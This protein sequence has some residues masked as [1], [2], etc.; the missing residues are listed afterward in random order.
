VT[1]VIPPARFGAK[2][3]G[4]S[5][6][7]SVRALAGDGGFPSGVAFGPGDSGDLAARWA[8]ECDRGSGWHH[9]Y[10]PGVGDR[11]RFGTVPFVAETRMFTV[12]DPP[13]TLS[14]TRIADLVM[15]NGLAEAYADKDWP[16]RSITVMGGSVGNVFVDAIRA[17]LGD[18]GIVVYI[19]SRS[20]VVRPGQEPEYQQGGFVVRDGGHFEI[21]GPLTRMQSDLITRELTHALVEGW[22]YAP[23][24][25]GADQLND[26]AAT[27][28][29]AADLLT[30]SVAQLAETPDRLDLARLT[31][32]AA[33]HTHAGVVIDSVV[34]ALRARSLLDPVRKVADLYE[35][36]NGDWHAAAVPIKTRRL[37][38]ATGPHTGAE[39][40]VLVGGG[41]TLQSGDATAL[42]A[43]PVSAQERAA[44]TLWLAERAFDAVRA[45]EHLPQVRLDSTNDGT[46]MRIRMI[47]D[48]KQSLTRWGRSRRRSTTS[49]RS[50]PPPRGTTSVPASSRCGR[51]LSTGSVTRKSPSRCGPAPTSTGPRWRCSAAPSEMS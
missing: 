20:D 31:R 29:L 9:Q 18:P 15:E 44:T 14:D 23:G 1:S 36:E 7:N 45:G 17:R 10:E 37:Y 5:T 34:A 3:A 25:E 16:L 6:E 46:L 33:A 47:G 32:G 22:R 40:P 24:R 49:R 4:N 30:Q 27:H 35:D 41:P 39:R 28:R 50:C 42:P 21:H 48:V 12:W 38:T 13:A 11:T 2:P 43:A 8:A 26:R 51:T 19:A